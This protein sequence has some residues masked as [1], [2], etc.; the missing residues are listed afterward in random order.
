MS[1]LSPRS[2]AVIGASADEKKVGHYV[3]KNLITQ[4]YEGDVYP[5][6]PKPGDILGKKVYPS[7]TDVPGPAIR[8]PPE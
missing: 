6:N 2:V 4:G 3:L 5:I 1:L 7:V 8:V